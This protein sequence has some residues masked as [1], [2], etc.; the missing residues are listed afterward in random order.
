M[1]G[2]CGS[3]HG[4][5]T[6]VGMAIAMSLA[7]LCAGCVGTPVPQPPAHQPPDATLVMVEAAGT[8]VPVL[9][10]GPGA[11]EP[12]TELWVVPLDQPV[13]D[14]RQV[15]A[16]VSPMRSR[17]SERPFTT[18]SPFSVEEITP[19][20]WAVTNGSSTTVTRRLEGCTWHDVIL[21][22]RPGVETIST[23]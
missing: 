20:N 21:P 23:R 3:G 22:G 4:V 16:T 14:R 17:N 11:A 15:A 6:T 13:D 12:R 10:G 5:S 9:V 7:L 1:P 19:M 8:S 18:A 2:G